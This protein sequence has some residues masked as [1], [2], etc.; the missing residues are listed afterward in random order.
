MRI[1]LCGY[2]GSMGQ[3]FTKLYDVSAGY[4]LKKGSEDYPTYEDLSKIEEE[5]DVIVDFSHKR[6][7]SDIV[8]YAVSK[9]LPLVIATTNLD[10]ALHK[11]ID[12]A[13]Q[14]IPILQS[15][16]FSKGM[17]VV[18]RITKELT[19][20]LNDFDIEI[21]E[22][23]HRYKEDA[24]SGS[25]QMLFDAVKEER[26]DVVAVYNRESVDKKRDIKDVGMHSLRGG[27]VVGEHSVYFFGDDESVEIKHTALSKGI[28]ARGA[29]NASLFL[30]KQNKG[31]YTYEEAILN[32]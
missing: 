21:E 30:L 11:K 10:D 20:L 5:F 16:N 28:F 13:S 14:S 12:Q 31:R 6:M 7:T 3:V 2:D 4:S 22:K 1:L 18:A 8:D 17:N 9:G 15:G 29:Y 25:A 26:N 24:P 27:T 19:K 32:D 23:H